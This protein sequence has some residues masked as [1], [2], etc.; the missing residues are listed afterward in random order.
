[1]VHQPLHPGTGVSLAQAA[2]DRK[3]APDRRPDEP[4][5]LLLAETR[6]PSRNMSVPSPVHRLTEAEYLEA[7][8]QAQFKSEFF[9]GEVFAMAGGSPRHSLIA[10][11]VLAEL[12]S[13]LKGRPCVV[14]NSDLRVKVEATGLLTYPDV[15]VVCGPQRLFEDDTLLNPRLVAEVLS[16]S[17][18]AYDRGRKFRHYRQIDS[19]H[20]YLLIS[21]A[22]P[23][24][25][26]FIRQDNGQWLLR[27]AAGLE[28]TLELPCLEIILAL[29]EVFA[30]VE[31]APSPVRLSAP[32]RG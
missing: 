9:D 15:S 12:R 16:E 8:R 17:T 14:F 30:K 2:L 5:C 10:G 32:S 7:E 31:F 13:H 3:L 1:M 25:E 21:Q 23:R 27:E 22:E 24:L 26:L 11:N 20:E 19:L 29:A 4:A 18:E 28:T 6:V